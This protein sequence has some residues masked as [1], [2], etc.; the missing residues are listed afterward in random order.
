[1]RSMGR[2]VPMG[3]TATIVMAAVVTIVGTASSGGPRPAEISGVEGLNMLDVRTANVSPSDSTGAAG[4]TRYIELVNGKVGVY[5]RDWSLRTK[6]SLQSLVGLPAALLLDPDILWAPAQQRFFFSMIATNGD[7]SESQLA[8]GFSKGPEPDVD[9]W[10]TYTDSFGI[11]G[12]E[13]P[14]FPRLGD[15]KEF[16]LIGVNRFTSHRANYLGSDLLWYTKP[17]P[18]PITTCPDPASFATGAFQLLTYPS[19]RKL[20]TPVPVKQVDV[21]GTGY[22]LGTIRTQLPRT[23]FTLTKVTAGPT[24]QPELAPPQLVNVSRPFS[25]PPTAPQA[26]TSYVLETLDGRFTQ[27]VGAIDP[28]RLDPESGEPKMAIW[29]QHSVAASAGGLGSEIRWYEIDPSTPG[30]FQNGVVQSDD[31]FVFNGAI[32][33]DR[34][35]DGFSAA[36]GDSMVLGFNTSSATTDVAIQMVSKVGDS[37]QS[38]FVLIRQSPGP[39]VDGTCHPTPPCRWGDFAGASPDPGAAPSGSQGAVWLSN[40]YNRSSVGDKRI[41]WL[42]WNWT[43]EP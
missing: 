26:G 42:T 22:V 1:M 43:A 13:F 37:P 8:F 10:C 17:P 33:P 3:T 30:L 15:T 38:G 18:G 32:A 23:S 21:S 35:V 24:G 12:S 41:D 6:S 31:L 27:A 29:T 20:F 9:G 19:G 28:A 36:F 11:Y 14:D 25:V 5:D 16:V 39:N 4:P 40:A 34:A 2:R 7:I